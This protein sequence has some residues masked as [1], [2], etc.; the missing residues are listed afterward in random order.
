MSNFKISLISVFLILAIIAWLVRYDIF[1]LNGSQPA[2]YRLDR[3]TG[4]TA[5]LYGAFIAAEHL[6]PIKEMKKQK[7]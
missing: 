4:R 5:T 2:A 1:I 7:Y 3:W 6:R